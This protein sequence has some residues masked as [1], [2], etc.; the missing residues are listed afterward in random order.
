MS[1]RTINYT[2]T[3][4][5]ITPASLQRGG[6]QGEHKATELI[7]NIENSLAEKLE[8]A[9]KYIPIEDGAIEG[10][11][12]YRFEAHNCMGKKD[13]T[14]PVRFKISDGELKGFYLN[15]SLENWLTREGGNITVYLIFSILSDGETHID[16]F[17]YPARLKL[18]S[19][20]DGKYTDGKNYESIA[21]LSVAAEDAAERAEEAAE[22]SETA[23]EQTVSARFALENGAEFIFLGG[24][25]SGAAEVDLVVDGELSEHSSNPISNEAVAKNLEKYISTKEFAEELQKYTPTEQ[26]DEMYVSAED[27]ASDKE[28]ADNERLE[29]KKNLE[30][31]V[32][33][34]EEQGTSG[35][36][37][38]RKWNSGIGECYGKIVV[39]T[40]VTNPWGN[41]FTSGALVNYVQNFPFEFKELPI[42]NASLMPNTTGA[43]LMVPGASDIGTTTKKTGAFEIY[44]G[45]QSE[46]IASYILVFS[47]IGTWK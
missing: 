8:A 29:N 11:L 36:W 21:K 14:L 2:V 30:N 35:I 40:T 34:V 46:D 15:Y 5:S 9:A 33:Y 10:E 24:D 26:A 37:T 25:A 27:Y 41:G 22:I 44:R 43:I 32:D 28:T 12:Y 38:Y 3:A 42:L 39:E 17:S 45:A 20:P 6:L 47:V 16:V 1:I 31:I 7:F 13:S 4:D 18:E 19:V 23:K